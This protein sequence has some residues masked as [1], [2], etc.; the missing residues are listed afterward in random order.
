MSGCYG[1]KSE[2]EFDAILELVSTTSSQELYSLYRDH[3]LA[4]CKLCSNQGAKSYLDCVFCTNWKILPLYG[5][6]FSKAP[7]TLGISELICLQDPQEF[8]NKDKDHTL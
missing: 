3:I 4:P 8:I 5:T 7:K 1:Q 6:I 2:L